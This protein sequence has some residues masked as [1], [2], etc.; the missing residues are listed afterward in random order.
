M[1]LQE[2][3]QKLLELGCEPRFQNGR[4]RARC[5]VHQ[6]DDPSLLV[7]EEQ[8]GIWPHCFAGCSQRDILKVLGEV[9]AGRKIAVTRKAPDI[10]LGLQILH[11]VFT[12]V[13]TPTPLAERE[14]RRRSIRGWY[15]VLDADVVTA[16]LLRISTG[17]D[18]IRAG[19]AYRT[20]YGL[21]FPS[22]F[23]LGR[24]VIPYFMDGR[25]IS[26]RSRSVQDDGLP[27]YLSL[28][29]YPSRV[30]TISI[31]PELPAVVVEGEFKAMVLYE[32]LPGFNVIAVPGISACHAEVRQIL[33]EY[34]VREGFI[35]F[36]TEPNPRVAEAAKKLARITG[37]KVLTVDTVFGYNDIKIG[38]DDYIICCGAN[39]V[40]S[41]LQGVPK[42]VRTAGPCEGSTARS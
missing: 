7:T 25:L 8:G 15:R 28:P 21:R 30:Y 31:A 34:R 5:P 39:V 27:K 22:I 11:E 18:L 23:R 17:E 20:R 41:T 24:V 32:N 26:I 12:A 4:I 37:S 38:P 3:Y 35:W 36:D 40:I 10:G 13:T 1:T 33:Q 16:M 19:L 9:T 29:G 42:C 2:C 14:L 6:D